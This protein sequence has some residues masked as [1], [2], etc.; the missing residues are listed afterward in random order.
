MSTTACSNCYIQ[1]LCVCVCGCGCVGTVPQYYKEV[2]DV[3]SSKNSSKVAKEIW[4][5]CFKTSKLTV[6]ILQQVS[7]VA[8]PFFL[9]F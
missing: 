9:F 3:L 1:H 7:K 4:L 2:Y 5:K 6:S 8:R